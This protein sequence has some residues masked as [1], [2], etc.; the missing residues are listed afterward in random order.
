MHPQRTSKRRN[1]QRER[2][3]DTYDQTSPVQ[4]LGVGELTD[5]QTEALIYRKKQLVQ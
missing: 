5:L 4:V 1:L 3:A 2:R